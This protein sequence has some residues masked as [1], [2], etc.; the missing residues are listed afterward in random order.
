MKI[1]GTAKGAALNTK[2]FGVA[3]GGAPAPSLVVF[4]E[5]MASDTGWT[6]N[7]TDVTIGSGLMNWTGSTDGDY[8]FKACDRVLDN[9]AWVFDFDF[10]VNSSSGFPFADRIAISDKSGV[11]PTTANNDM[12]GIRL[13]V[14][15]GPVYLERTTKKDGSGSLGNSADGDDVGTTLRYW[16]LIRTSATNLNNSIYTD[17]DRTTAL[18]TNPLSLTIDSTIIDLQ[19]VYGYVQGTTV[20]CQGDNFKIWD[21]ITERP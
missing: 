9:T 18:G 17:S 2:D 8:M 7:G 5:D 16:E 14:S 10:K 3:F 13:G 4:D 15:G 19:Y 21:G 6:S 11:N 1:H 12:L 20:A